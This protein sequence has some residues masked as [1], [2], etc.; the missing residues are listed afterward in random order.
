MNK[1]DKQCT[2]NVKMR[3]VPATTVA[4]KEQNILHITSVCLQTSVFSIQGA[5]AVF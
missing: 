2:Y 1:Q 3:L 4:V 5:C